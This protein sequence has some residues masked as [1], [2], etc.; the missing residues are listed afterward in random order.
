LP[1]D[2]TTP[3][4]DDTTLHITRELLQ[5]IREGRIPPRA[6]VVLG[7]EHVRSLCPHCR[8]ELDRDQEDRRR[9]VYAGPAAFDETFRSLEAVMEEHSAQMDAE[10]Q[11]A[12]A[13]V[14]ELLALPP[15]RR[16]ERVRED[17]HHFAQQLV[18]RQLVDLARRATPAEPEKVFS[19]AQCAYHICEELAE[20]WPDRG[21]MMVEALGL[22]GNA[23][24]LFDRFGEARVLFRLAQSKLWE[25]GVTDPLVYAELDSF[26]A[27]LARVLGQLENAA[28]LVSRASLIYAG[29]AEVE[30]AA[31]CAIQ[32]GCIH[33]QA[34]EFKA[35]IQAFERAL[36]HLDR[37][38]DKRLV[39]SARHSESM[40]LVEL[41]ELVVAS[42]HFAEDQD[43][44]AAFDDAGTRLRRDWL[45]GRLLE[46]SRPHEAVRLLQLA[47]TGFLAEGG[48]FD[49]VLVSLD[50]GQLF[51]RAGRI[52]ELE[53]L[54]AELS[55]LL[56]V[57]GESL[58]A[59]TLAILRTVLATIG[60]GAATARLL[61]ETAAMLRR[62][63]DR[64]ARAAGSPN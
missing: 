29:L 36:R 26:R 30:L 55:E 47:R 46:A 44:Y 62:R 12:D 58:A 33:Y 18:P 16:L 60:S 51:L 7:L 25:E 14:A 31:R 15:A 34:G 53:G 63:G 22:M 23:E 50:L 59:E 20:R 8:A 64:R 11:R 57:R 45:E 19:L 2:D 56:R 6:L 48:V 4:P 17:P 1:I 10:T 5:A 43:L 38:R 54:A 32:L 27:S 41:G 13:L 42:Q 40:C 52:A 37:E 49:S 28:R 24:R 3:D 61:G 35:G 9:V 21:G 39:L